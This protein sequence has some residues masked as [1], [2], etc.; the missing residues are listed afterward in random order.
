MKSTE[1]EA[2]DK[3]RRALRSLTLLDNITP[4]IWD[5]LFDLRAEPLDLRSEPRSRMAPLMAIQ[6]PGRGQ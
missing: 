5:V 2:L 4:T 3:P 6:S 1:L